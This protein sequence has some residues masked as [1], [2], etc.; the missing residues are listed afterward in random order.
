MLGDEA[1]IRAQSDVDTAVLTEDEVLVTDEEALR[2]A[3]K[4]RSEEAGVEGSR[5]T[6]VS[7]LVT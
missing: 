3:V 1:E 5:N 4:W 2:E 6:Q 7:L